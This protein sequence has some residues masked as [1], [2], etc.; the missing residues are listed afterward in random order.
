MIKLY[1]LCYILR[2]IL[3]SCIT[4]FISNGLQCICGNS[5]YLS[6]FSNVL[7]SFFR[8]LKRNSINIL[9]SRRIERCGLFLCSSINLS[10]R[11]LIG[12]YGALAGFGE[13]LRYSSKNHGRDE[14]SK[15]ETLPYFLS[16]ERNRFTRCV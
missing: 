14:K 1:I 11:R 7:Q 4:L 3:S 5:H 6:S 8:Y 15:T 13:V 16:A 12:F 10:Q 9:L 2:I